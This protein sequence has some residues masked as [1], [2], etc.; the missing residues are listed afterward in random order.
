ME[1]YASDNQDG[2]LITVDNT[3]LIGVESEAFQ[4]AVK[5]SLEKG[6][7]NISVDLSKVEYVSSWGI[8]LLIHA[9]T[10]C[11]NKNVDFSIRGVNPQVMNVLNQLKLTSLFK[12]T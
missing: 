2:T 10:S 6:S 11:H 9:Y 4:N 5:N 1:I 3:K 7:K 12:I 8:G